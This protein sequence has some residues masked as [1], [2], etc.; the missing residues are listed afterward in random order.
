MRV[1]SRREK[2]GWLILHR[3]GFPAPQTQIP[4]VDEYGQIVAVLDMGW[5][6]IKLA[7][8]YDGD[9][10]WTDRRQFKKDIGRAEALT[11]LGWV[12]VR[13]TAD[14][15]EGG[16][17]ARVS[18]AWDPPSVKRLPEFGRLPAT[19]SRST[20]RALSAAIR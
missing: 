19:V 3:A 7:V 17:V 5:E 11:E 14:D 2:A 6:R 8:E 10:H 18:A 9:H 4:V 12:D 1:P 16:V 13:V 20:A 15:T